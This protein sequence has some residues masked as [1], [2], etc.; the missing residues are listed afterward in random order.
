MIHDGT[1]DF[2]SDHE[3]SYSA[4][5]V[6]KETTTFVLRE[7]GMDHAKYYMPIKQLV[8]K[9]FMALAE[10]HKSNKEDLSGEEVKAIEDDHEEKSDEA[11]QALEAVFFTSD[12]V[13]VAAFM[14]MFRAMACMPC[15]KP[16]VMLDGEQRMTDAIWSNMHPDDGLKMAVRWASFFAMPSADGQKK[17]SSKLSTSQGQ[18]KV[19]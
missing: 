4:K 7:P 2:F 1:T 6:Q 16:I 11:A 18:A 8:M 15:S 14:E 3:V 9:A 10:K 5:G 19:V 12:V 17:S 13:D